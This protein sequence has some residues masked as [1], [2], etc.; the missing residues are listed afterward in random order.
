MFTVFG[1][2]ET[3][4]LSHQAILGWELSKINIRLQLLSVSQK[5][6]KTGRGR[7][8]IPNICLF[9]LDNNWALRQWRAVEK[10]GFGSKAAVKG[11]LHSKPGG[12]QWMIL[13]LYPKWIKHCSKQSTL[14]RSPRLTNL[15]SPWQVSTLRPAV[16]I[17]K[18]E[19][20][21]TWGNWELACNSKLPPDTMT[22]KNNWEGDYLPSGACEEIEQPQP[23][24][25]SCV[26]IKDLN[27]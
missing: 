20:D 14:R 2:L 24:P 26:S 22:H 1:A 21:V 13:L 25:L 8:M 17:R 23:V 11:C 12:H 4:A 6:L 16:I 27:G 5:M 3:E 19:T 7:G 15:Y 9:I 18:C 10:T